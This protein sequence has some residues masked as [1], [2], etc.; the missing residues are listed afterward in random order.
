MLERHA[1][2]PILSSSS[3]PTLR[4]ANSF[5][6]EVTSACSVMKHT[7]EHAKQ[8]RKKVFASQYLYGQRTLFA[9]ISPDTRNSINI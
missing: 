8:A 1:T 2:R 7:A 5:F 9:T 3:D 4:L 6:R